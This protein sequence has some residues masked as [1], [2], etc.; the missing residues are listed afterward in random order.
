MRIVDR[1]LMVLYALFGIALAAVIGALIYFRDQF[2]LTIN[3]QAY[4]LSQHV[5][6]TA[7]MVLVALAL[8]AW[9]VHLIL[10]ATGHA[11]K[12]KKS[13]VSV[14]NVEDGA[15]R[16]SVQAM[17]ILVKQAVAKT[18]G[19]A[20]VRTRIDNHGDSITVHIEMTLNSDVYIPNVTTLMQRNIKSFVQEYSGISVREVTIMVNRIME[21]QPRPPL[22]IPEPQVDS[23]LIDE[24]DIIHLPQDE[25]SEPEEEPEFT[26]EIEDIML[27]PDPEEDENEDEDEGA[28]AADTTE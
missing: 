25:I 20:D 4:G 21:V 1:L 6:V 28:P 19:I 27:P 8:V 7:L 15:V 14:Q 24:D 16:V 23:I 18:E 13:S 12:S 5:A 10:V 17:D 2:T 3:G 11:R 22:K 26:E 9:S